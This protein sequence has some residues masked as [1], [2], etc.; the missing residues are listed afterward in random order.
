MP[1]VTRRPLH[2]GES[3][4]LIAGVAEASLEG[5]AKGAREARREWEGRT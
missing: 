4:R 3:E 1:R 2:G 5:A